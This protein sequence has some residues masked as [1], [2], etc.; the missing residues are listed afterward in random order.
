MKLISLVS[1][2]AGVR[3]LSQSFDTCRNPMYD[4]IFRR[5]D[6]TTREQYD[7]ISN[8]K[9]MKCDF[10]DCPPLFTD[11]DACNRIL[12]AY[13]PDMAD[14]SRDDFNFLAGPPLPRRSFLSEVYDPLIELADKKITPSPTNLGAVDA[15]TAVRKVYD[16]GAAR[17]GDVLVYVANNYGL[18]TARICEKLK[19][20]GV[21]VI[22]VYVGNGSPTDPTSISQL[23]RMAETQFTGNIMNQEPIMK[24]IN[25]QVGDFGDGAG[26]ILS[27]YDLPVGAFGTTST[28]R[29]NAI[30]MFAK[31][32]RRHFLHRLLCTDTCNIHR[33]LTRDLL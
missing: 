9:E 5:L 28:N 2:F 30:V 14:Y 32:F 23:S 22:P 6:G 27:G 7:W 16:G 4:L 20:K 11:R 19:E 25:A 8:D 18:T 33:L 24:K 29:A 12:F 13:H 10:E 21:I 17:E 31:L 3:S 26:I 1:V 15:A